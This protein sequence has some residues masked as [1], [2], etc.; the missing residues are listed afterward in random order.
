MPARISAR[1]RRQL[2]E[3]HFGMQIAVD[4]VG[5]GDRALAFRG[6]RAR[7]AVHGFFLRRGNLSIRPIEVFGFGGPLLSASASHITP[8]GGNA[9]R[10]FS[11]LGFQ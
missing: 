10:C 1:R 4:H 8:H 3:V 2:A 7:W 11:G 6:S 9:A 5:D